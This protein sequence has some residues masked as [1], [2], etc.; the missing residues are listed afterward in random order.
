MEIAGSGFDS[1][2]VYTCV[3]RGEDPTS[4]AQVR[5]TST[6]VFTTPGVVVC[7]SPQWPIT[8]SS[9]AR[10]RLEI[11]GGEGGAKTVVF[12]QVVIHRGGGFHQRS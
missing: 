5:V 8:P 1:S 9:Y 10:V 2:A 7:L 4:R 3:F 11:G 6:A 12:F